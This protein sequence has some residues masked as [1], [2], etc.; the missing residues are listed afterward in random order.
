M[1]ADGACWS[2]AGGRG[3]GMKSRR[4]GRRMCL[5]VAIGAVGPA[6]FPTFAVAERITG[7]KFAALDQLRINIA[8]MRDPTAAR[9]LG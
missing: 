1:G 2:V 5:W 7:V 4:M 8:L 9:S 6:V 3:L